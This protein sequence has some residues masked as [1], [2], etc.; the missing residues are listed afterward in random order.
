MK[1]ATDKMRV[2]GLLL[3]SLAAIAAAVVGVIEIGRGQIQDAAFTT[4][5]RSVFLTNEISSIEI[6]PDQL[7]PKTW[8]YVVS[9][10]STLFAFREAAIRAE[11]KPISGH[12][13]PVAEWTLVVHFLSGTTCRYLASV[14]RLDT[15]DL[16]LTDNFYTKTE[17]GTYAR[18][19]SRTARLVG[20]AP[21][22]MTQAPAGIL[23]DGA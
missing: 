22:L 5:V 8:H 15:G 20:I 14:N 6:T 11:T 19:P 16:F 23:R 7:S 17:R 13:G 3:F 21:L 12:S 1:L 9:E 18:G 4:S 10:K 2:P